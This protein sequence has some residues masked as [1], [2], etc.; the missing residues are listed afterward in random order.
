MILAHLEKYNLHFKLY[1]YFI[2]PPLK[3]GAEILHFHII[4]ENYFI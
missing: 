1:F 4:F 3:F 2:S